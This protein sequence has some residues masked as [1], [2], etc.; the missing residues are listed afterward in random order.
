MT[1]LIHG[2]IFNAQLFIQLLYDFFLLPDLLII[3]F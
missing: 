3:D 2:K 1:Q